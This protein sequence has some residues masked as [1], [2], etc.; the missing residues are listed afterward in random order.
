MKQLIALDADGVLLDYNLAYAAAWERAF[1]R[2]PALRDPNAYWPLDR[3]HVE[4]L[5]GAKL[6]QFR[7]CLDWTFWSTVPALPGAREACERLVVAGYRLVC[8][9]AIRAEFAEARRRNLEAL[10]FP[11]ED[12][13]ATGNAGG[14][15][16]PKAAV[17]QELQP[18]AFVDD[19]LP[20][21]RGVDPLI[22]KALILREPNG[23]PN[24][25]PELNYL[26]STHDRLGDFTEYWLRRYH[27]VD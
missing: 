6:D 14:D 3:W 15:V 26:D 23:S 11:L 17:L 16:S 22:H 7:A 19:Y 5:A 21:H 1:G 24:H 18:V 25:G 9:S 20:Y 27:S 4:R 12:F 8:V 13:V 10:G 2:R